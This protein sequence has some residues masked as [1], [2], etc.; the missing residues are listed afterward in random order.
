MTPPR[1]E[2]W[3]GLGAAVLALV[4][5]SCAGVQG[6]PTASSGSG[7]QDTAA[8]Q[9]NG[10]PATEAP[11]SNAGAAD[12]NRKILGHLTPPT[13]GADLSL[14]PGDLIEISVFDVPEFS[15]LKLRIPVGGSVTLPLIGAIPAAGRTS[16]ELEKEIRTRLQRDFMN[17]PQVSVFVAEQKSQRISVI[18]AVRTGGVYPLTG[19]LRL[20]DALA[21][22]GGLVDDAGHTVYVSRRV[23]VETAASSTAGGTATTAANRERVEHSRSAEVAEVVTAIDLDAFVAGKDE[24][25][26]LLQ[27][28]D[29]INIPRAG[30]YYVGGEVEHPG[31]FFLKARTTVQQAIV[32]AGGVKDVADWDDLRLYRMGADGQRQVLAFSLNDFEHGKPSPEIRQGDIVIVGRSVI[33]TFLYAVRDFLRFGVGA[34]LPVP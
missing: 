22:A 17:D 34:T 12:L 6:R 9:P 5:A 4:L 32:T 20:A 21:L 7:R 26:L 24:L 29:V 3:F 31:S 33:K 16:S 1:T 15:S 14:G 23:P 19:H 27:S 30:S 11:V 25:N 2:V 13:E 8:A 28:G 18:G 10:A